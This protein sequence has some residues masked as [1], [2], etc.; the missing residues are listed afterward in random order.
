LG[1][2]HWGRAQ[3]WLMWSFLAV[4]RGLPA[5]D[6]AM[7]GFLQDLKFFADGVVQTVDDA[8]AIHA[9]AN[10]PTS[11]PETTGTA[12]V[13][14]GLHEGMRRG[15]LERA[16]YAEV[17]Q[18]M[19]RFCR[20]HITPD[21]RFELVYTEWALPAELYVESSRTVQFGPH[22]GALLWLA[23]EMTREADA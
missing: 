23:N 21:G 20:D 9:F 18:R 14:I 3:G 13:A 6:P 15:W 17:A 4:M 19:W 5:D 7:A 16:K 1:K 11:L 12:M 2:T 10:D 22:I 8:G